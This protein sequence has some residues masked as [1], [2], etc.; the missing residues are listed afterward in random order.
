[1]A[2]KRKTCGI[3][4]SD[5]TDRG[6][7][8]RVIETLDGAFG[9]GLSASRNDGVLTPKP[10]RHQEIELNY[11]EA[12]RLVYRFGAGEL[13]LPPGRLAVFWGAVPHQVVV[14]EKVRQLNFIHI[15]LSWVMDWGLPQE[16]LKELLEGKVACSDGKDAELDRV[17]TKRWV[18]DIASGSPENSEIALME[19]EARLRRLW[20]ERSSQGGGVLS[21]ERGQRSKAVEMAAVMAK[22]YRKKLKVED[23]AR[24][25]SLH[26]VYAMA[27]FKREFG[28]TMV[29]FLNRHRVWHAQKL[30]AVSSE[31]VISIALES[32]F[33]SLSQFNAVFR[34]LCGT[35]PREFRAATRTGGARKRSDHL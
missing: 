30:L 21:P 13:T 32:G 8:Q 9:Y 2:N 18:D 24:R 23:L 6:K 19:I 10:D 28:L 29:Q 15:P 1:M 11:L 16:L 7:A 33:G 25:V 31:K 35:T 12:G 27:L 34:E 22:L 20:L 26:P 3:E 17:L 4:R 5:W 14:A